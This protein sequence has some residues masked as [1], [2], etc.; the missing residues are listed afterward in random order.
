MD[1]GLLIAFEGCDKSGKGT[2][3]DELAKKFLMEGEEVIVIDFPCYDTPSGKIIE[4]ILGGYHSIEATEGDIV[5]AMYVI[6]RYEQ[7][8]RIETALMQGKV[9][10]CDRYIYS[11]VA[12]GVA[13]GQPEDWLLNIQHSLVQPDLT[14][15]LDIDYK[16]YQKRCKEFEELD[17]M[18]TNEE[19]IKGTI[20]LYQK[21]AEM[22]E[23]AMFDGT[24]EIEELSDLIRHVVQLKIDEMSEIDE[25]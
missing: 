3:V 21:F 25:G 12:Y 14:I 5:Q 1:R 13:T 22:N 18:E 23:W 9:V 6:N 8:A 11:S 7:Q 16:E 24:M 2:Q 19:L 10:I 20:S 17:E 15:L 4:A